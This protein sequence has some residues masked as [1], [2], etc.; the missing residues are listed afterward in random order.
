MIPRGVSHHVSRAGNHTNLK[1]TNITRDQYLGVEMASA[2]LSREKTLYNSTR[3]MS[4]MAK[5][6]D[7][8]RCECGKALGRGISARSLCAECRSEKEAR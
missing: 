2:E 5:K 4:N 6:A 7:I 8:P 3:N 1:D